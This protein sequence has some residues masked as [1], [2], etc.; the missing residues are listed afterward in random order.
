MMNSKSFTTRIIIALRHIRFRKIHGAILIGIVGAYLLFAWLALPGIVQTQAEKY[1][2]ER[3][4]HHLVMDRPTFNPFTLSLHLKNFRLTEPDSKALLSFDDLVVDFS[5]T[6]LF[7]RAYVFDEIKLDGLTISVAVLPRDKLNWSRFIAA[8]QSKEKTSSELPRVIVKKFSLTKGRLDLADARTAEVKTTRLVPLNL[9]LTDLSTLPNDRGQYTLTATTNFGARI[10]WDGQVKLKPVTLTGSFRVDQ[11]SLEKLAPYA[12]LP[13]T[14]APPQG[15]ASFSTRYRT[16]MIANRFDLKLS[17]MALTIDRFNLQRKADPDTALAIDRIAINGGRFHLQD[18]QITVEDITVSG[19]GVRA[20]RDAKGRIN[21]LAL[22][23]P[24]K[25]MAAD[26][27]PAPSS[28]AGWH[29]SI[30]HITLNHLSAAFRDHSIAP[31]ADFA[32]EN[33][34]AKIDGISQDMTAAL[35]AHVAFS[36]RDGGSFTAN[37]TVVP[38]TADADFQIKL[39]SLVLTPAQPYVGHLTTLKLKGGALSAEGHFGFD[40]KSGN[41]DGSAALRDLNIVE[42]DG[43]RTFL[44][45]KSLST[46]TL[47]ASTTGLTVHELL[48]DGL[49]TRFIIAKDKSINFIQVLRQKPNAQPAANTTGPATPIP[50]HIARL[51]ISRSQLEFAD[52]SL[53]L[54]F[55]THIHALSGT[56]VNISSQRGNTPAR[57]QVQGQI[58]DYG[59]ARAAGKVDLFKPTDDLDIK[60]DFTNVEMTRL[61]PYSATFAGRRIDSGKLTL[62]LEYKIQN[63][64]LTGNNRIVMDQ[65]T[66]GERVES[67]TAHDLPLD[68]AIAILEDSS[69]RI[70]LGL[71]VSGSLDDP[72]FSYS[73][74]IWQAITNVLTKIVTAPFRALGALFGDDDKFDGLVFEAGQPQLTPPE[75]E[76]LARL[77]EALAKRPNLAVTVH[78]MFSEADRAALQDIRLRKA[79]AAKL[80]LS[81]E[82]DPGL[83][84]PDQAPVQPVLEDIYSERFGRGAVTALKEAFRKTNPGALPES[85]SG[86]VMSAIIGIFSA[87][88]VISEAEIVKMKGGNFYG[89]LYQKLRDGEVVTDA[90]LQALADAR[91][92]EIMMLLANAKAPLERISI[93]SPEKIEALDK[94]VPLKM[95]MSAKAPPKPLTQGTR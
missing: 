37:G 30:A 87:K 90:A 75:R 6:S 17:R 42:A 81:S 16:G 31:A 79:I 94:T 8:F 2:A 62:N 12:P 93:Q 32:L 86:R 89:V 84:T 61:T 54:P 7:R 95:D 48:L 26:T 38:A 51:R 56:L 85:T 22:L 58:D 63:R 46:T 39:D 29:Y 44:A 1:V 73:S 72:K 11:V 57:L 40:G 24:Q 10:H 5:S 9:T 52:H 74:I 43:K 50:V 67:P 15:I 83:L 28:L 78:G 14:L 55:G 91:G 59:M 3:S 64:Q 18:R 69:G 65:I 71:P 70:D 21:L 36:S 35:P 88:P 34:S 4:S 92:K 53:V 27:K 82:G 47:S 13:S 77:A 45:W 23:P 19:G 66:L 76:K 68:L 80:H 49:D 25:K 60:V 33:I 41:Y 20:E